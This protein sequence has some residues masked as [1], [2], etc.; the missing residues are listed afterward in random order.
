MSCTNCTNCNCSSNTE[1][2][3]L[4]TENIE[5]FNNR[6]S[7]LTVSELKSL[8]AKL[9]SVTTTK[10]NQ[11]KSVIIEATKLAAIYRMIDSN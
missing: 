6:I 8:H 10:I 3:L 4:S 11:N 7:L 5:D 9:N 2:V 1:A